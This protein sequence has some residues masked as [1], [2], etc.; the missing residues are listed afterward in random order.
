MATLAQD[1]ISLA[2]LYKRTGGEGGKKIAAVINLLALSNPLYRDL[3]N[4]E[5]N[6]GGIHRHSI[7]T[8]LPSVSWGAI[9]EGI[10]QSKSH[11][12]QVDD[13]TGFVEG[14]ST[15]DCRVLDLSKDKAA[16]RL[17]EAQLFLE[18]L[19]QEVETAFFYSDPA[20]EPRKPR[21]MAPR[22]NTVSHP[23]VI[24]GGGTGSDNMS[25]WFITHGPNDTCGIYPEGTMAGVERNDMGKQRVLDDNSNPYYVEEEEFRQHIG[26]A[27]KD[28]RNNARVCNIDV[29]ELQAGNVDIHDLMTD[30]FYAMHKRRI[31]NPATEIADQLDLGRT[32]IYTNREGMKA[33]DKGQTNNRSSD[34]FVRLRPMEL[35]G[36]EV[37]SW[38]GIPIRETDALLNTEA[39]IT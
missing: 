14:M 37:Q 19:A 12:Q 36:E 5:C 18:A 2:D 30:A 13:V 39:Q 26:F 27:V 3:R 9:Y 32:M 4:Y 10:A 34:N 15:I 35:Q 1:F 7:V 33:I 8:G 29:S 16:T 25:L 38:R 6:R 11:Q 22:Y 20:T 23:N 31:G 28:W 17:Q 24:D 21:G